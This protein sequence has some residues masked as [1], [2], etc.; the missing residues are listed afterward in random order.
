MAQSSSCFD[1]IVEHD[2]LKLLLSFLNLTPN[3]KLSE[4][5]LAACERV[6]QKS[7]IALT[8]LAKDPKYAQTIVSSG[9]D[10]P[11]LVL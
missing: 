5:E 11:L 2:G 9:G 4:A 6:H 3:A 7:A 10:Y 8:R 1:E